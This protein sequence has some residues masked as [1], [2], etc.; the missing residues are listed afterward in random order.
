MDRRWVYPHVVLI[1]RHGMIR[2]Q[3][4]PHGSPELQE[5]VTLRPKIEALLKER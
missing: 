3:S 1:D 4:D 5:L 2:E